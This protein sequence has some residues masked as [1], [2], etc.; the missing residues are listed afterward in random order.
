MLDQ[1]HPLL[2]PKVSGVGPKPDQVQEALI[3]IQDRLTGAREDIIE[4]FNLIKSFIDKPQRLETPLTVSRLVQLQI[5]LKGY[6]LDFYAAYDKQSQRSLHIGYYKSR[7]LCAS[8]AFMCNTTAS[9]RELRE[10]KA[11]NSCLRAF[12]HRF[13][14]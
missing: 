7:G 13:H 5:F 12:K 8:E 11:C 1:D 9:F 14:I 3:T 4:A 10:L 6:D 2:T